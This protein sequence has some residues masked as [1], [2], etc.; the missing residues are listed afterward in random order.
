MTTNEVFNVI[1]SIIGVISFILIMVVLF[2]ED[3]YKVTKYHYLVIA[4]KDNNNYYEHHIKLN[5]KVKCNLSYAQLKFEVA[6]QLE[7]ATDEFIILN[8]KYLG[9]NKIWNHNAHVLHY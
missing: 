9:R 5:F 8:Y 4:L 1:F 3:N 2:R 7:C 6:K